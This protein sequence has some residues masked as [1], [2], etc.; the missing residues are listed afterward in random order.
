[1]RT[2]TGERPHRCQLCQK[3]FAQKGNLRKHVRT[4][5]GERPHRCQL[6][7]KS[8]AEL[9]NLRRHVSTHSGEKPYRCHQCHKSFA[10]MFT[11]RNHIRT[12]TGKGP[13]TCDMTQGCVEQVTL[14]TARNSDVTSQKRGTTCSY[15]VN[16]IGLSCNM[17]CTIISSSVS[18]A[19]TQPK[20]FEIGDKV[21]YNTSG[22][23]ITV[24]NTGVIE[25]QDECFSKDNCLDSGEIA[26]P[27][28]KTEDGECLSITRFKSSV[29][30]TVSFSKCFGCGIC[31]ELL[32]IEKDFFE[33]CSGHG[34]SPPDDLFA[35]LF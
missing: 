15:E 28:P 19:E 6:C 4:H 8:F 1:M 22:R 16:N 27:L 10:R 29:E 21:I 20:G 35:D 9:G 33:H 7:Q 17:P 34:F 31:D 14:A 11:L 18:Q 30:T 24:S 23:L 2:H 25:R 13:R 12:H 26:R 5:S 3:S 32:E